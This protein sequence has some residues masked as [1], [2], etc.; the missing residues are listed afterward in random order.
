MRKSIITFLFLVLFNIITYP[1]GD[2]IIIDTSQ[3]GNNIKVNDYVTYYTVADGDFNDDAIWFPNLEVPNNSKANIIIENDVILTE[4][5]E[6]NILRINPGGTLTINPTVTLTVNGALK[7]NVGNTGLILKSSS[8]GSSS[9]IHKTNN[10]E[11]TM[12][13]Y[14]NLDA[15]YFSSSPIS[16]A[17]SGMFLDQYMFTWDEVNYEW[18]NFSETDTPLVVGKGYDIYNVDQSTASYVGTLNNGNESITGLTRTT[19]GLGDPGF[20]LVGNPYPSCLDVFEINFPSEITA[21]SY[22]LR[23]GPKTYYIWSQGSG[24][25]MEARYIQPGQGFFI[26]VLVNN[27]AL[28]FSNTARTHAGLGPL[29]KSQNKEEVVELLK[30]T[31][32]GGGYDDRTYIGFRDEASAGF[33]AYY[34]VRKL[35]S[36]QEIPSIFSY[37]EDGSEMGINS[38]PYISDSERVPL[39]VK[40]FEEGEYSLHISQLYSFSEDQPFYL[41]DRLVNKYYNLRE[42]SLI[43]FHYVDGQDEHRFDLLFKEFTHVSEQMDIIDMRIYASQMKIYLVSE[44]INQDAIASFYNILGQKIGEEKVS[45]LKSGVSVDW[46][47]AYYLVKIASNDISYTQKFYL[48]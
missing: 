2:H 23:H 4:N 25:D 21:A 43:R 29:D 40:L 5:T 22:V 11:A 42:D 14:F 33:D 38:F 44:D 1:Q 13:T 27:Q 28:D 8:S 34:D 18:A 32:L 36:S 16:D 39:G 26:E 41:K 12:E 35:K 17:V 24:G 10:V 45:D 31:L 15:H 37:L 30:I 9:L 3:G 47:K 20:N 19:T 6:C 7:N 48:K 46:P